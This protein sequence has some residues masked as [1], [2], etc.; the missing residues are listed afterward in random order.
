MSAITKHDYQGAMD[1]QSACNASGL[2]HSLA[3]VTERIWKE[4][5]IKGEGTDFVN[6]HPIVVLYV[7]QLAH[8]SGARGRLDPARDAYAVAYQEC[9]QGAKE[10]DAVA[11]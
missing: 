3:D 1:S 9:E 8:L 5:R 10:G 11:A 6:T 4:A 2:I 7:T